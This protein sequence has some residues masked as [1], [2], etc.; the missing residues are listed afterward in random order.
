MSIKD[1]ALGKYVY[2]ES[3]IHRLDPRTKLFSMFLIMLGIFTGKG[4]LSLGLAT[5]FS[6]FSGILSGIKV[7]YIL[8][9]LLPFKWLLIITFGLNVIFI[10]GHILIE[11]PLP[12]GGI[13]YEGLETGSVYTIRIML[14]IIFASLLTLTTQP[15]SLVAGI[16]KLLTPFSKI[17]L[18]PGEIALAMIIT[19]RFIPVLIDEATRIQ[20]SH[21]ARGLNPKAGI[22]SGIKSASILLIPLFISSARR[23]E[24]LAVAMECRLYDISGKRTRYNEIKMKKIDFIALVIVVLAVIAIAVI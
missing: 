21:I 14:L 4:W 11:A 2:G 15:V 9:S 23:A 1:I 6:L 18:N 24:E 19:I 5:S 7:S 20:K 3:F 12:Y 8:K 22:I 13:S 16:E 10:G 17:G